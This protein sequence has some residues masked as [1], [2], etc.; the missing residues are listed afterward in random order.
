[1]QYSVN[2][3]GS[4]SPRLPVC[5]AFALGFSSA[6]AAVAARSRRRSRRR[7]RHAQFTLGA[8]RG[9]DDWLL[10]GVYSEDLSLSR[11][12]APFHARS[13]FSVTH[14]HRLV[15]GFAV[16]ASTTS[17]EYDQHSLGPCNLCILGSVR[18]TMERS[19]RPVSDSVCASV[20]TSMSISVLVFFTI[21]PSNRATGGYI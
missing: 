11:P 16:L 13:S 3:L 1:M 21:L 4:L 5:R 12:L 6:R 19:L 2:F 7:R 15:R 20:C 10:Y 14:P 18:P 8:F 9:G 17:G